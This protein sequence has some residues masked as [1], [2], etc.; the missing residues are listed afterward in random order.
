MSD[1]VTATMPGESDEPPTGRPAGSEPPSVSVL[2]S[3]PDGAPPGPDVAA[4][5]CIHDLNLDQVLAGIIAG[6]DEYGLAEFFTRPVRYVA[7]V[8]HRQEVFRDLEQDAVRAA[9]EQFATSMRD[10]RAQSGS[11]RK[12]HYLWQSERWFLG[13]ANAYCAAAAR[14]TEQLAKAP[15]TSR[16]L[17]DLTAYLERYV[18]SSAFLSLRSEAL[19]LVDRLGQVHYD[20]LIRGVK[21]TA[22]HYDEEADYSKVVLRTFE[23]FQQGAV[24]DHRIQHNP[25]VGINHV[26]AKV[27]EL[28]ASL[29]PDLFGALASFYQIR[30]DFIDP[31]ILRFD[32]EMQFYFAYLSFLVP[33]RAAGL[34]ICYPVVSSDSKQVRAAA[35]YDLA[36]ADK[37]TRSRETVVLNDFHLDGPERILV[38]SGPNQGGKTT[39]ARTFGQLA[40]L[41]S[42]GCPVPGREVQM[43]LPDRIL[44]HFEKEENLD[45]ASGK[46]EDELI[47]IRDIIAHASTNS[48]IILNEM[49]NSTTVLDAL[50]LGRVVLTQMSDLDCVGVCVTFIDELSRLSEKTVSMVSTVDPDDPTVRTLTLVRQPADGRAYAIA[51]AE[52]YGLTY[53]ALKARVA[54]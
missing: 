36:L 1:D 15:L 4:A 41:A 46:L 47:P 49:F 9:L 45:T 28:V 54:S 2:W 40:Y 29:N 23:R 18:G 17:T 37:L 25:S 33:I 24:K 26:E 22:G 11:A 42:L 51:I 3:T 7:D 21:I 16:G 6:R 35:A 14:L 5:E 38:V 13:A 12:R 39:L 48:V 50:A 30:E 31:V 44:T 8:H 27:L 34:P 52:K 19:D 10:A 32:R 43:P 53:A 20:L